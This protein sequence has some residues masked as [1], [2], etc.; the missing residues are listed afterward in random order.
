[1]RSRPVPG[2][3]AGQIA[4]HFLEE[5]DGRCP[6]EEFLDL[7][8]GPDGQQFV[9]CFRKIAELPA[10]RQMGNWFKPLH[11]YPNVW[12]VVTESHRVL[13]FRDGAILILT[14]GFKKK[15]MDTPP[16]EIDRCA[17]LQKR[18]KEERSRE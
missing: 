4:M 11:H 2:V 7:L 15:R 9:A 17:G 8:K 13:G 18:F 12:E 14:N 10:W 3:A 6:V 16:A 1:M 5:D